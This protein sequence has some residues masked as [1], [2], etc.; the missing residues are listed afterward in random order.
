[1]AIWFW[2]RSWA[3]DINS[4]LVNLW[5]GFKTIGLD[6]VTEGKRS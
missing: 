6:K 1:M 4:R 3:G 5:K 2:E